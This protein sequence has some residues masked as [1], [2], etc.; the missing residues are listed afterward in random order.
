MKQ[1][2][3]IV[4]TGVIFYP[5][6]AYLQ[7]SGRNPKVSFSK[8]TIYGYYGYN[9]SWY[10]NSTIHYTGPGYQ[11]S[12]KGA[13]AVDNPF[14]LDPGQQLN[15][16]KATAGQYNVRLGYY[17][18]DHW[19]ISLGYDK[20]KYFLRDS[21]QVLLNGQIDPG[22]DL[23]TNWNGSYIN[24]PIELYHSN[25]HYSNSGLN[26]LRLELSRADQWLAAGSHQE[27]IFSTILGI[28]FGGLVSDNSFLFAG[29]EEPKLRSFSGFAAS[30][31]LGVR[32]EFFK[33]IFIQSNLSG[34]L[35]EQTNVRTKG[36]EPNSFAH[37]RFGYLQF[38]TNLGFLLYIRPV[39]GC[40]TCPKW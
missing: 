10:S 24:K 14:P 40:D 12:F 11:F 30:G 6:T 26:Y 37:Q 34:G 35:M 20:L 22:I 19:A 33:H 21:D 36:T 27:I 25:F 2:F 18:K 31:H 23:V 13:A 32:L 3:F 39:K 17:I 5:A 4:L 38:D 16:L 1:V 9:R 7:S 15:P 28:G 8:G 29:I